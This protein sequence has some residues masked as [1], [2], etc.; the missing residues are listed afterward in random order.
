MIDVAGSTHRAYAFPAGRAA[1]FAYYADFR[2]VVS[3]LSLISLVKAY[4]G[5]RY[6]LVYHSTELGLY[7]VRIFCDVQVRLD[8]ENWVL[9]VDPWPAPAAA[10][11]ESGMTLTQAQGRYS[12]E[13][14]FH[15]EGDHTR[16][17]Y[18]LGLSARLPV[19]LG[20][21]LVPGPLL[22][23]AAHGITARRMHDIIEDFILHS[24]KAFESRH[25]G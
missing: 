2:N 16:I 4:G 7:R 23:G 10:P 6:R 17:E 3:S 15:D 19:P 14:I 20:L 1:A 18:R 12:S 24:V 9:H 22:D 8:R 11:C 25:R 21:R 5:E 13:S